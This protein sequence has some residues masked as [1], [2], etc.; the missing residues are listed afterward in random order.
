VK[1]IQRN[2]YAD[3][4]DLREFRLQASQLTIYS[5]PRSDRDVK[6]S[7]EAQLPDRKVTIS[8]S[9]FDAVFKQWQEDHGGESTIGDLLGYYKQKL[10]GGRSE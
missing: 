2:G 5:Q 3:F 6:I 1:T 4:E 10:F 9:E 7:V 8:E